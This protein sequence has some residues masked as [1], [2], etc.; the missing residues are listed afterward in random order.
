MKSNLYCQTI[1]YLKNNNLEFIEIDCPSQKVIGFIENLYSDEP[2]PIFEH[3]I[4]HI[5]SYL[6]FQSKILGVNFNSGSTILVIRNDKFIFFTPKSKNIKELVSEFSSLS[7]HLNFSEVCVL[8]LSKYQ[9]TKWQDNIREIK[10]NIIPRS[11]EEAIYDVI[12]LTNLSGKDFA[13]LRN[14]RNKL[15][16][17][18]KLDFVDINRG[19]IKKAFEV[20]DQWDKIQGFKY[21]KRKVDKEKYV[22]NTLSKFAERDKKIKV[23]LI[24]SGTIALGIIIY[25]LIPNWR[26]WGEI[27]MVKGINRGTEGGVHGISDALYL[28]IFEEFKNRG[29]LWINDGELGSEPGTREH[30]MRFQPVNFLQSFDIQIEL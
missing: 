19:N 17:N 6:H 1:K 14:T 25:F 26:E 10:V 15:L 18:R 20:I 27:Y 21:K 13:K 8:N 2:F 11:K 7:Q 29:V 3:N 4:Y 9:L 28:K 16:K 22:I 5:L 23:Q 12:K 24:L 30:K